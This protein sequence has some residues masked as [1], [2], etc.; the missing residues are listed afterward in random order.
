MRCIVAVALLASLHPVDAA[1][2][3]AAPRAALLN[4][5]PPLDRGFAASAEQRREVAA[6]IQVLA[7][8][9]SQQY[10][11]DLS[12]DWELLY[13][14]APDIL[15]LDV[16]AGPLATC[17][18]IGQQISEA[19]G[20]ITNVIEYGPRQWV[21][22]LVGSAA[23]DLLQQRVITSF[24]RRT[25]EPTKVDLKIRGA[26]F[27]PKQILG[28]SLASVPPLK[29]QGPVEPPFGS[30][31]VLYCEGPEGPPTGDA[32]ALEPAMQDAC[33]LDGLAGFGN[34]ASIRVVR[35]LQGYYSINRRMTPVEGWGEA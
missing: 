12:G 25:A 13:T 8:A 15:G 22:S 26:A 17:T 9:T 3:A 31:E 4:M 30:F 34:C 6:A 5:L 21:P 23:G 16:Q 18:R 35:T 28:V 29:L 32:S 24:Q 7:S 20:T 10:I 27:V 2:A 1:G 19:D 11:P 14:D 33:E